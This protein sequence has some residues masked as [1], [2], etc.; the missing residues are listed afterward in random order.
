[1]L[2]VEVGMVAVVEMGLVLEKGVVDGVIAVEE[3]EVGVM[4]RTVN[5][6]RL[7]GI[8]G[9]AKGKGCQVKG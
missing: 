9:G 3:G 7:V 5:R 8:K 4:C 6:C 1:M 2:V